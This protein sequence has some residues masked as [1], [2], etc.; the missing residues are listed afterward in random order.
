MS[1]AVTLEIRGYGRYYCAYFPDCSNPTEHNKHYIYHDVGDAHQS[2]MQEH[3]DSQIVRQEV[4]SMK[5]LFYFPVTLSDVWRTGD[6]H[7]IDLSV[8]SN[9]RRLI[10]DIS[11][12]RYGI[13]ADTGKRFECSQLYDLDYWEVRETQNM[14][15]KKVWARLTLIGQQM[16]LYGKIPRV[17]TATHR[18]K[19]WF[20]LIW[21]S[22]ES[23]AKTIREIDE[24]INQKAREQIP[25]VM[26]E[27]ADREGAERNYQRRKFEVERDRD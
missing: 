24:I 15:S 3:Y 25:I 4:A 18:G 5:T 7:T 23:T 13:L 14:D 21:S 2:W 12:Y 10:S 11:T 9:N 17:S 22:T 27:K 1:L 20:Y 8:K 16:L 19:F 6:T 26:Q